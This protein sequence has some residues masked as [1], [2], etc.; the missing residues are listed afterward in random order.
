MRNHR[1]GADQHVHRQ[2]PA[3][4]L[5]H[6]EQ[7]T[8]P[9]ASASRYD[10]AVMIVLTT[11]PCRNKESLLVQTARARQE[12]PVETEAD[13]Q[14]YEE[15]DILKHV[16]QK[17]ALKTAK[18]LAKVAHAVYPLLAHAITS[19]CYVSTRAAHAHYTCSPLGHRVHAAPDDRLEGPRPRAQAPPL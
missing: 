9:T 15:E 12:Q 10:C 5:D 17:T 2:A 3:P 4:T 8:A 18:E 11:T 16:T 14:L 19:T 6:V 1:V 7:A 13:K